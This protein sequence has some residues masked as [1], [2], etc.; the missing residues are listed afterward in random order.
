MEVSI[1]C[2]SVI[3]DAKR[4]SLPT[5][6][7]PTNILENRKAGVNLATNLMIKDSN[8]GNNDLS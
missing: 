7:N 6:N 5:T 4:L 8:D 3:D 1:F 2:F